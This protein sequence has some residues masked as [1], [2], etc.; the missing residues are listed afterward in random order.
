M[1]GYTTVATS[2][3]FSLKGQQIVSA[4][5]DK[6]VRVW[7]TATGE[8]RLELA[9]HG[10]AVASAQFSTDEAWIVSGGADASV[11]LGAATIG[12]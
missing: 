5:N 10:G 2:A 9:G 4:S 1:K 3:A 7:D 8:G 12:V 6:T 11:W